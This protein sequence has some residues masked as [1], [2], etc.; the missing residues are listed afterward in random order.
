MDELCQAQQDPPDGEVSQLEE[1]CAAPAV[2][3]SVLSIPMENPLKKLCDE[4]FENLEL[5]YALNQN[6]RNFSGP[7]NHAML[8]QIE[9]DG[10]AVSRLLASRQ[11][12]DN[13]VVNIDICDLFGVKSYGMKCPFITEKGI[14]GKRWNAFVTKLIQFIK[15]RETIAGIE[16][17]YG[18]RNKFIMN[19]LT[20]SFN[21]RNY[22]ENFAT[23]LAEKV[24]AAFSRALE[25]ILS[26]PPVSKYFAVEKLPTYERTILS[27][28]RN[29]INF[30]LGDLQGGLASSATVPIQ[31]LLDFVTD[32][33]FDKDFFT[34]LP[35]KV[36]CGDEPE[37]DER[38]KTESEF[39]R[40]L[41]GLGATVRKLLLVTP[42]D[43][44][45]EWSEG[46][47]KRVEEMTILRYFEILNKQWSEITPVEGGETN[48]ALLEKAEVSAK[49]FAELRA[50]F[51]DEK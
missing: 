14:S 6:G 15:L 38:N 32:D 2:P 36:V 42:F 20:K 12:D 30:Q 49:N 40:L 10:D 41:G 21:S 5:Y 23:M 37:E 48:G 45:L 35:L 27:F 13:A 19:S 25:G 17:A 11:N 24:A 3:E 9:F 50:K 51:L 44:V 47:P 33:E 39:N 4:I 8:V 18:G 46:F 16:K 31:G 29:R 34:E 7:T 43:F 28:I 1:P 26:R 22:N